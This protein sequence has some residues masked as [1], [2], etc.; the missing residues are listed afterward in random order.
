MADS[1]HLGWKD[2]SINPINAPHYDCASV[3]RYTSATDN[4]RR[5]MLEAIGVSS[6]DE[7]F[8]DIPEGMR[9][10]R[11][12]ALPEGMPETEVY[13]RLCARWRRGTSTPRPR[14]A[15]SAPGCTT[16]TSPRSSTRSPV[17]PSSSPRTRRISPR[18]PRAA[19]RRCSSSR[20][21]CPSSPGSQS[22][23]PPCTRAPRRSPRP[24]T[25]RSAP[26]GG[27]SWSPPA[28][29]TRTAAS[30]W[31]PTGR[32]TAPSWSRPRHTF[33]RHTRP[34][35]GRR[36]PRRGDRRRDRRGLPAAAQLPWRR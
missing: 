33:G 27:G 26:P 2:R 35:Y 7:L 13:D 36:R 28:D 15:S 11:P 1:R 10:E 3:S 19:C 14:P 18:S 23:T 16:T 9:L 12:L 30:R 4:D 31:S 17:A 20:P 6:I 29:S 8:D 5:E 21:R 32:A 22:P 34:V 25:S 24:P